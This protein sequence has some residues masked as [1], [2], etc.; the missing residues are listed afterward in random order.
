MSVNARTFGG[1]DYVGFHTM[2]ALAET[3]TALGE[4]DTAIAVWQRVL[5]NHSYAR[6]RVQLAELYAAKNELGPAR[7]QLTE[8]LADSAYAP[9]FDR[10][11]D[12]IW[13]KRAKKLIQ[14]I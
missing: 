5:E 13:I 6:A 10:Q 12:R 3:L 7:A 4:Q 11:R 14:Q 1:E 8:A 2:M 9:K